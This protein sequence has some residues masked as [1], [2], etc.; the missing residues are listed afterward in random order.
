MTKTLKQIRPSLSLMTLTPD[1]LIAR[2][3]AVKAG[4]TNNPAYPNP[5]TDAAAL[6][7]LIDSYLA[8]VAAGLDSKKARAERDQLHGE[9][10]RKVR[11]IGH[12]VEAT[13]NDDMPTFLSS[14]F[15]PVPPRTPPQPLPPAA[16]AAVEQG[17]NSGQLLVYLKPLRKARN[18]EIKYTPTGGAGATG[19][20]T[21]VTVPSARAAIP[22]DGL[23][24]GTTYTFQVRGYGKLG[25]T[26]WS[27]P[28]S[29]MSI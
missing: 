10:V 17:G 22:I 8:A 23:T 12:Y 5:P 1:A 25:F 11:Q 4:I 28:A 6:G 14:G 26:D 9:L 3:N 16:I 24:P 18:Y 27:D 20:T 2:A 21:T 13:C 29:R 15:Q 19:T 7:T